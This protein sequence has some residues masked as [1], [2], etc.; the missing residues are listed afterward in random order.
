[1][2]ETVSSSRLLPSFSLKQIALAIVVV[3]LSAFVFYAALRETKKQP[4]PAP[5]AATPTA[6]PMFTAGLG[7]DRTSLG[8][9]SPEEEAYAVALWPIHS[10]VKLAAMRM[11]LAGITY[12]ID[13]QEPAQL[14]V[15]LQPLA[16]TFESAKQHARQ[17]HAP[18]SLKDAHASY[19]EA[20][21]L[22]DQAAREMMKV[23]TNRSDQHLFVAHERSELASHK[24]L[25][26]SDVLWPGEYKP[27]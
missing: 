10:E 21:E 1:M 19:L 7:M 12:K 5:A 23:T 4:P 13:R 14:K 24:L 9:L 22:Y 26:L 16:T 2:S 11:T 3:A 20:I 17:L 6:A 27:N 18:Q 8:A 25:Q 15:A